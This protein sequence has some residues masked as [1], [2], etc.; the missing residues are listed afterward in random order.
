MPV[1]SLLEE[2]GVYARVAT[3]V[4][5]FVL[6]IFLR[7]ILGKNRITRVLVTIGTMWFAV[8]LLM[9]PYSA[10]MQQD[11]QNIEKIFR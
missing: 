7:V 5:P 1:G 10:R 6:A 9:S 3:I 8:S 4:I 2:I 11:L